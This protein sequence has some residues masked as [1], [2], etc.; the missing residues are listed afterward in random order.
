MPVVAKRRLEEREGLSILDREPV[1][2][3]VFSKHAFEFGEI[4]L[5]LKQDR[6]IREGRVSEAHAADRIDRPHRFLHL[7]ESLIR[8][9]CP[10]DE[11]VGVSSLLVCR[12]D[13]ER[14]YIGN[15]PPKL[16]HELIQQHPLT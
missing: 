5:L 15:A 12:R 14:P 10:E 3:E 1:R 16:V 6:M 7:A 2:S 11:V 9:R 4:W 8:V 13:L